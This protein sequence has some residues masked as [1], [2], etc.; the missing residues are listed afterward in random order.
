MESITLNN[1]HQRLGKARYYWDN[2]HNRKSYGNPGSRRMYCFS[3]LQ[4]HPREFLSS[5]ISFCHLWQ[6]YP[7]YH[8]SHLS[9]RIC[10]RWY[11]YQFLLRVRLSCVFI[12]NRDKL[13]KL[14]PL[15]IWSSFCTSEIFKFFSPLQTHKPLWKDWN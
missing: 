1:S 4:A 5:N 9:T 7:S 15:L 14:S 13:W 3:Y 2:Y 12:N 10:V 6:V 11:C 8:H